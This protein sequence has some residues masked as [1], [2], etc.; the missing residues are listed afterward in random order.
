M[1]GSHEYTCSLI[2]HLLARQEASIACKPHNL[3]L[4]LHRV[5]LKGKLLNNEVIEEKLIAVN[6]P[7]EKK[8]LRYNTFLREVKLKFS[9]LFPG[10]VPGINS[11]LTYP[12]LY[13]SSHNC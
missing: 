11:S 9:Q 13:K 7:M 5:F 3:I 2:T 12:F 8:P 1:L 6:N 10:K 4:G